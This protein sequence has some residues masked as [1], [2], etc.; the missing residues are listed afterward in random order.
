MGDHPPITPTTNYPDRLAGDERRL[1]D[2]IS[3]H[4]IASLSEDCKYKKIGITCSVQGYTFVARG[5]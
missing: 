5:I 3:K 2:Y 4:F 1:Y